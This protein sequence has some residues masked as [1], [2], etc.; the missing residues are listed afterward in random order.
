MSATEH[1]EMPKASSG[2]ARNFGEVRRYLRREVRLKKDG[3][4]RS[5]RS[6]KP[7]LDAHF[8]LSRLAQTSPLQP[9]PLVVQ[10]LDPGLFERLPDGAA[11]DGERR[12]H[13]VR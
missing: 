12:P 3:A 8:Y 9:Q 13:F 11:H 6:A 4:G 2:N 1:D 10:E 5:W 7:L